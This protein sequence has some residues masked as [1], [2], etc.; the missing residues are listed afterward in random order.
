MSRPTRDDI[1]ARLDAEPIGI[2]ELASRL[3]CRV[4]EIGPFLY[5][6]E[7]EGLIRIERPE[8]GY[9]DGER[10]VALVAP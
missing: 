9:R 1:L 5:S 4:R 2:R 7:K 8:G 10:R 3:E 6:M